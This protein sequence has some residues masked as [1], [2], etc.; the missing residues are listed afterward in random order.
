MRGSG[1]V[2]LKIL[3]CTDSMRRLANGTQTEA[4]AE[5]Q[6]RSKSET[7]GSW[8][9][10]L[11]SSRMISRLRSS[12]KRGNY[13]VRRLRFVAALAFAGGK[14]HAAFSHAETLTGLGAGRNLELGTAIDGGHFYFGA[15]SRFHRG[16]GDG[17]QDVVAGA[18]RRR[19][20]RYG[21]SGRVARG[22]AM[23][24]GVA[25]AGEA[26][27]L[28]IAGAG[29]DPEVDGLG[30]GDDAFAMTGGA[31]VVELPVPPQRG[32]WMLNFMRPPIWVTWPV[33]LH[34]GHWSGP[35]VLPLPLQV[36]HIS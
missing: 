24:A 33:P 19:M 17:D 20:D 2:D 14:G 3:D 25:F 30:L 36:V 34:S 9:L 12:L 21:R 15:Q 29:L 35:P 8:L 31:D 6:R 27:A 5:S 23:H 13:D 18:R 10:S 7:R 16:D 26:D 28:S 11:P 22:A 32:H 4:G 1:C